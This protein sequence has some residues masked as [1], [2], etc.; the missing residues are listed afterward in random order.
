M[1]LKKT[2]AF[3]AQCRREAGLTQKELA[4]RLHVSDR[5]VSKW[6]RGLNLP[7][8]DLFEPL[9]QILGVTVRELLRG[10]R[11]EDDEILPEEIAQAMSRLELLEEEEK[12]RGRRRV[13]V[14][15]I[16][17]VLAVAVMLYFPLARGAQQR[18]WEELVNQIDYIPAVCFDVYSSMG[19]YVSRD[20]ILPGSLGGMQGPFYDYGYAY[21]R[22]LAVTWQPGPGWVLE[23][24]GGAYASAYLVGEKEDMTIQVLR[25]PQSAWG[26]QA[27]LEDGQAVEFNYDQYRLGSQPEMCE[28]RADCRVRFSLESGWLYSVILRWGEEGNIFVE[29]PLAVPPAEE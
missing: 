16:L 6:E 26:T 24:E 10:E 7:G 2:G 20:L 23:A 5:A 8:A 18:E 1:N 14:A 15:A 9:C 21:R 11:C 13:W 28:G 22:E 17:W 29:Y 27:G 12:R 3:I 19:N 4:E 25:W